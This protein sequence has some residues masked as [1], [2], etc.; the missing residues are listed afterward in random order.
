MQRCKAIE[1]T[2]FT[3]YVIFKDNYFVK[4]LKGEN[5]HIIM[6]YD[7]QMMVMEAVGEDLNCVFQVFSVCVTATVTYA[8]C[9]S[10]LPHTYP[11]TVH[12]EACIGAEQCNPD[13]VYHPPSTFLSS[14]PRICIVGRACCLPAIAV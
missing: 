8:D 6:P 2:N 5:D 7:A 1:I 11:K 13:L 10:V 14:M 9:T 3:S 4:V 12:R